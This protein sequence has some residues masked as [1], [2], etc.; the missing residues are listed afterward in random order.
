MA[1]AA[2]DFVLP[3]VKSFDD[4]YSVCNSPTAVPSAIGGQNRFFEN[5]IVMFR[6]TPIIGQYG[7]GGL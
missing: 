1:D 4:F 3:A 6:S 2:Q 7:T 5:R